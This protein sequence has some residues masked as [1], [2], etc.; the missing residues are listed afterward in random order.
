[1][2]R[3][4]VIVVARNFRY[5]SKK[6]L[7]SSRL[8]ISSSH[9][10]S[11]SPKKLFFNSLTCHLLKRHHFVSA[12]TPHKKKDINRVP[13]PYISPILLFLQQKIL[14]QYRGR[15]AGSEGFV[16]GTPPLPTQNTGQDRPSRRGS[17]AVGG[18]SGKVGRG[19]EQSGV[20]RS[21]YGLLMISR[22]VG[23][24]TRPGR[25]VRRVYTTSVTTPTLTLTSTGDHSPLGRCT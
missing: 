5:K 6:R 8:L 13:Q 23:A 1:M 7:V 22:H 2:S 16:A 11:A 19:P 17:G 15:G 14:K 12:R 20:R 10:S 18:G 24:G 21:D 9:F 3:G 25:L 4:L